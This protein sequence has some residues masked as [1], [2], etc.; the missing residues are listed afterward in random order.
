[1]GATGTMLNGSAV[2]AGIAAV[3]MALG[4]A[5]PHLPGNLLSKYDSSQVPAPFASSSLLAL[6]WSEAAP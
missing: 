6:P 4:A 5:L 1:M 3:L 2:F